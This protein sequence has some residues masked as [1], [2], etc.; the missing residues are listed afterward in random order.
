MMKKQKLPKQALGIDAL[1]MIKLFKAVAKHAKLPIVVDERVALA[2]RVKLL[3]GGL[4][5]LA[6]YAYKCA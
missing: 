1:G 3:H 5:Q 4:E 6:A 2:Q